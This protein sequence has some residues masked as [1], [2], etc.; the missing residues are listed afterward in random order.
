MR[1][2]LS[3]IIMFLAVTMNVYPQVTVA[4]WDNVSHNFAIYPTTG[5]VAMPEPN[6]DPT[7]INTSGF[8]MKVITA[9][10]IDV[11]YPEPKLDPIVF[12]NDQSIV[13]NV[14]SIKVLCDVVGQVNLKLSKKG[15]ETGAAEFPGYYFTPGKWQEIKFNISSDDLQNDYYDMISIMP[16]YNNTR[17]TTWYIDDIKTTMEPPFTNDVIS[18]FDNITRTFASPDGASVTWEDNPLSSDPKNQSEKV[19]KFTTTGSHAWETA[20]CL[21]ES[22]FDFTDKNSFSLKVYSDSVGTI[23]LEIRD[24]SDL[25]VKKEVSAYYSTPGE[26]QE[27]NF[28]FDVSSADNNIYD[29]VYIYPDHGNSRIMDWYIDDVNFKVKPIF[30]PDIFSNF[31]DVIGDI[32]NYTSNNLVYPVSNPNSNDSIN[33]TEKCLKLTTSADD[34]GGYGAYESI[35]VVLENKIDFSKY[36]SNVISIMAYSGI[37]GKIFMKLNGTNGAEYLAGEKLYTTINKW[38]ELTFDI[39]GLESD[40]Y[41]AII[42]FIDYGAQNNADWY[43]DEIVLKHS[44]DINLYSD[45]DSV[46]LPF[47]PIG[48]SSLEV[49]EDPV[50]GNNNALKITTY[51]ADEGART[52]L[53]NY[54][55]FSVSATYT[56]M[57]Y[58]ATDGSLT[59][60][61]EGEGVPAQEVTVDHSTAGEWQLLTFNF[62]TVAATDVYN[63]ILI[64]PSNG[65]WY[66]DDLSGPGLV[67]IPVELAITYADWETI[68]PDTLHRWPE[69]SQAILTA[70]VAV[71]PFKAGIN[72]SNTVLQTITSDSTY[73]GFAFTIDGVFDLSEGTTFALN[74]KSDKAGI[75]KFKIESEY[76]VNSDEI[77]LQ[78]TKVGSWQQLVYT[79]R[80]TL[81]CA[82]NK[83]AIFPDFG[84]RDESEWYFD[85]IQ[86]PESIDKAIFLTGTIA[87]GRE[88]S[89]IVSVQV[90]RDKYVSALNPA[91]W[92]A[93][94]LPD[95]VSIGSVTKINDTIVEITLNGNSTGQSIDDITFTIT[96]DANE[97]VSSAND[98]SASM[99]IIA[100]GDYSEDREKKVF[101]HYMPWYSIEAT[102]DVPAYSGWRNPNNIDEPIYANEPLIG[103]YSQ[104]DEA[105]LEYHFLT[106]YAAGIDGI[107][108]NTNPS[109]NKDIAIT[110]SIL[111]KLAQ[112]NSDYA[113][114]GFNLKYLISYDN[115]YLKSDSYENVYEDLEKVRDLFV[116]NSNYSAYRFN[117]DQDKTGYPV[118][119]TWS[120]I[121]DANGVGDQDTNYHNAIE[122]LYNGEVIYMK[123]DANDFASAGGTFQWVNY[124]LDSIPQTEHEYWGEDYFFDFDTAMANQHETFVPAGQRA[125]LTM[126]AVWPGFNDYNI[127]DEMDWS[128]KRW[129]NR[130]VDAGETMALTF[131]KHINYV[132]GA[133]GPVK[134]ELPWIQV[135]TWNDWPEGS[136]I[137]PAT[138]D[139]YGYR[140]LLTTMVKTAEFKDQLLPDSGDSIAVT[141]PYTIYQARKSG[142]A[143][144]AE[145]LLDEFL[146]GNY[147]TALSNCSAG[148]NIN[149]D[150]PYNQAE[151]EILN[152]AACV[153]MILDYEGANATSQSDIQSYGTNQNYSMNTGAD[154]IDPIGMYLS[155]NHFELESGYN[156]AQLTTETRDEA[157]H[158]LCYWISNTIPNTTREHL[159]SVVPVNGG[160]DNWFVVKGF[161][162]SADP[163][164]QSDYA[165]YGFYVSDTRY[166][167]IGSNMFVQA[168]TF[169]A[170]YYCPISSTDI[171]NGKYVTVDEPPS[172]GGTISVEPERVTIEPVNNELRYQITE[173]AFNDYKLGNNADIYEVLS[174]GFERDRIYFVDLEGTAYD[175]YIVSYTRSGSGD[176]IVAGLIDANNGALKLLAYNDEPD[177]GYYDYLDNYTTN[178]RLKSSNKERIGNELLYPV[179]GSVNLMSEKVIYD[180][181]EQELSFEI[182][183]NPAQEFAYIRYNIGQAGLVKIILMDIS[184]K[185]INTIVNTRQDAGNY[186]IEVDLHDM[187]SGMY[188]VKQISGNKWH[189]KRLVINR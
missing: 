61:L 54:M 91:H 174:T 136:T 117:D 7:G 59:L 163:H 167:G 83:I 62:E 46:T 80:S 189:V 119:I 138:E 71:N 161:Q 100:I 38:Q 31:D 28:D 43:I 39:S 8:V 188:F 10:N 182:I 109:Y 168:N 88:D 52:T 160:F 158:D 135:V 22:K 133:A 82:F 113:S 75:V 47:I 68:A 181:D 11:V 34:D 146:A 98:L 105:V 50:N 154:F 152:G 131:D 81:P 44:T 89:N 70:S 177:Y 147:E 97:F 55:D 58:S 99:D 166:Q 74:V 32:Y 134:V 173:C 178:T 102:T 9:V 116:N 118:I 92:I 137:E 64:L 29:V 42:F 53:N 172:G 4:D 1:K 127:P 142:D 26:W 128:G 187:D 79:F 24:M 103:E 35:K 180:T 155:L 115:K 72:Q 96:V 153:K 162:S 16:D 66:I 104:L 19:M 37:T 122:D 13:V 3:N 106:M 150:L 184:G 69:N 111:N 171:W 15:T 56:A 40:T 126:G 5:S 76:G 110:T 85:N 112:M 51:Q 2:L 14:I 185:T 114:S 151:S 95:N 67:P 87:E 23:V 143:G 165:L 139:T 108:I 6:P 130:T 125:Y 179:K 90:V 120:H 86:G 149:L 63:E 170:H 164:V 84:E 157:Y 20:R 176:V 148:F 57:V 101:V 107:I 156:Y 45:W 175:Y 41:D 18:D 78:Y 77:D 27:I 186:S 129:I 169:S 183:P 36:N 93:A 65:T 144:Y 17:S 145:C 30:N 94:G 140:A 12:F 21:M 121:T 132:P 124:L 49:T 48:N 33:S 141:I 60:K 73:E 25:N 159:P 123:R